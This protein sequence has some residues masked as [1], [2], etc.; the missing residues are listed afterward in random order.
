MEGSSSRVSDFSIERILAPQL[1]AC[2][3]PEPLYGLRPQQVPLLP[4]ALLPYGATRRCCSYAEMFCPCSA[5]LHH[6]HPEF[7]GVYPNP[8]PNLNPNP[9]VVCRQEPPGEITSSAHTE[10]LQHCFQQTCTATSWGCKFTVNSW[11]LAALLS[12]ILV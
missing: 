8:N 5:G 11:L 10:R 12:V 3:Y 2:C 6:H 7:P 4:L 9:R 1:G